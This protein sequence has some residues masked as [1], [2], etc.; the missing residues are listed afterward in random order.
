MDYQNDACLMAF[1]KGQASRA[2][3]TFDDAFGW[4][5][6]LVVPN[7]GN[8]VVD[9]GE[10]CDDGNT[11]L[12]D[13][14]TMCRIGA[15]YTC[16]GA[17]SVCQM[18][19]SL[20]PLFQEPFESSGLQTTW[21][22][23]AYQGGN[24]L[25]PVQAK[26]LFSLDTTVK[27]ST[28]TASYKMDLSTDNQLVK[29]SSQN[30][31]IPASGTVALTFWMKVDTEGANWDQQCF[32]AVNLFVAA[33]GDSKRAHAYNVPYF[34]TGNGVD[35]MKRG[36]CS[37]S[38]KSLTYYSQRG[39]AYNALATSLN[40][41]MFLAVDMSPWYGQTINLEFT[42]AT[43]ANG[44]STAMWLDQLKLWAPS[45]PATTTGVP[46]TTG[47]VTTTAKAPAS[48]GAG[49]VLMTPLLALLG[50]LSLWMM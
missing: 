26:A 43:D 28:S 7:C 6:K 1:T 49:Q 37:M 31:T 16:S 50:M 20:S 23:A 17:P 44:A 30:I 14:C 32:D 46:T 42:S 35:N 38:G 48:S 19:A 18:D 15:G 25:T 24:P 12:N 29:L 11:N 5:R 34:N 41:W 13:G 36:W 40:D 9:S 21:S 22:Y 27:T 3:L 45:T 2:R 33:N 10:E 47:V 39:A 8:G 4:R